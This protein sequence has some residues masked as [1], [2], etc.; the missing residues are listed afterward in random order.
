M[1]YSVF[2][3]QPTGMEAQQMFTVEQLKKRSASQARVKIAPKLVVTANTAEKKLEVSRV[4]KQVIREHHAVLM[5]LK[6]R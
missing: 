3:D 1:H 5:A 2:A 6:N 4:A